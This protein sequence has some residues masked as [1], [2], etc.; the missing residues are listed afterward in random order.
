MSRTNTPAGGKYTRPRRG[1]RARSHY[2]ERLA[3]RGLTSKTVRS[4]SLETLRKRQEKYVQ[5]DTRVSGIPTAPYVPAD[6]QRKKGGK[7]HVG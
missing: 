5:T 3:K 1:Y 2:R 6:A 4:E 7:A